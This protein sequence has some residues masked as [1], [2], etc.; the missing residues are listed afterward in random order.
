MFGL[1]DCLW[2]LLIHLRLFLERKVQVSRSE[3]LQKPNFET[4][5]NLVIVFSIRLDDK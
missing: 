5:C 3:N 2:Y 1:K 4:V